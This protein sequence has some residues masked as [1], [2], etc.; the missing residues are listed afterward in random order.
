MNC[1]EVLRVHAYFD[2]ELDP[3]EVAPMQEH[4]RGCACCRGLLAD[5]ELTRTALRPAPHLRAPARLRARVDALLDEESVAVAPRARPRSWRSA[6]FWSGA[7]AGL[8]TAA[9]AAVLVL[10]VLVPAASAPLIDDLLAAHLHSLTG[11]H[12]ISVISG[13]QHT[14]K[15]WFAGRADVSPTVSDF[16]ANGFSLAGGRVDELSGRRAAVMVYRHGAHVVNVFSWPGDRLSLPGTTTR[17]GYHLLFWQVGDVAYCA[18]SD[19]AWSELTALES[20]IRT[21]AAAEQRAAPR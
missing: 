13:E 19:S 11:D 10:F 5:L 17:Q 16:R 14:V 12:L 1:P 15:P 9:A 6:A 21:Q 7:F 3:G 20:L 4:L 8:G 18:I 2:G